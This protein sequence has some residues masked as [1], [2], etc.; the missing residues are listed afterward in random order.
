MEE[1]IY[2]APPRVDSNSAK[3]VEADLNGLLDSGAAKLV[4]DMAGMQYISSAGLRVLLSIQKKVNGSGSFVLRNVPQAVRE[5]L[6]VTGFS[7]L[8]VIE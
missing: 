3:S 2:T 5:I 4:F 7:G 1:T 8:L 6:D